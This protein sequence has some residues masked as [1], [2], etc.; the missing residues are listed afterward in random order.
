MTFLEPWRAKN[1]SLDDIALTTGHQEGKGDKHGTTMVV[2][3][4]WEDSKESNEGII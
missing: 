3:A 1:I 4:L 2:T